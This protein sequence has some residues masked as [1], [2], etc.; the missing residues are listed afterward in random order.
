MSAVRTERRFW[1][2]V[3]AACLSP[4]VVRWGFPTLL[5]PPTVFAAQQCALGIALCIGVAVGMRHW[6][7][8]TRE[9]RDAAVYLKQ[10]RRWAWI[11]GLGI[12]AP[13]LIVATCLGRF[14]EAG[15]WLLLPVAL[16]GPALSLRASLLNSKP[17][18]PLQE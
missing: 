5:A 10:Q 14:G 7:L 16:L 2:L 6:A 3:L 8:Q 15:G 9:P 11:L 17:N 4:T 12:L 13:I 1:W 18:H